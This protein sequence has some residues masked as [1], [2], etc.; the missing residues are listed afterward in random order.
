MALRRVLLAWLAFALVMA[1]ALGL[2]HNVVHGP[3][4]EILA[5]AAHDHEEEH[6]AHRHGHAHGALALLFAGHDEGACL[7]LDGLVNDAA[8]LAGAV[9]L[10]LAAPAALLAVLQ[11]GFLARWSAL[12]DARGPPAIR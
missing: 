11:G 3:H 5:A 9:V 8:P 1:Q 4:A 12:F 7:L 2:V 6:E 10:P